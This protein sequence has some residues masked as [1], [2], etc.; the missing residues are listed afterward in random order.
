[1]RFPP[2]P[3]APVLPVPLVVTLHGLGGP[4][5]REA[6]LPVWTA[7]QH[8]AHYVAISQADRHPALCYAA[9]IHHGFDLT[10]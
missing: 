5:T 4:E 3:F 1:M 7:F 9:T 10:A 8:E 6:V 2:L